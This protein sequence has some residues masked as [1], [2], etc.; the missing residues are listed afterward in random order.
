MEII[1]KKP[2]FIFEMANNHMGDVEHGLKIIREI[3]KATQ[4][5]TDMDWNFAF[6]FQYRDLDTFIHPDYKDRMD[7]KYVKRFSETKLTE[8]EFLALKKE[9]EKLG[10]ITM[11]TPFDEASVDLVVKHNYDILKVASCSSTDWS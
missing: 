10:F 3:H 4:E 1:D 9:A 8:E 6:K 5:F 7:L 11:C 2:L